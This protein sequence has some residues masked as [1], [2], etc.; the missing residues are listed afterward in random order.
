MQDRWVVHK[1]GRVISEDGWSV[2]PIGD[3]LEYVDGPDACLV[4]LGEPEPGRPRVIYASE[5]TN[6]FFPQLREHIRAALP[7][8][9]G[10]WTLT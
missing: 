1:D 9:R 5:S 7:F 10:R 6:E 8:L 4:N 3:F 2:Q